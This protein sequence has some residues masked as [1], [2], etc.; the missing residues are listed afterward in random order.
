MMRDFFYPYTLDTA[1][2][3]AN[4]LSEATWTLVLPFYKDQVVLSYNRQ[5][6]QWELPGGH[7]EEGETPEDTAAR[8]C[9]EET[10]GTPGSLRLIG[11]IPAERA[12]GASNLGLVYLAEIDHL[13]D[14][15]DDGEIT[16]RAVLKAD[17]VGLLVQRPGARNF[18]HSLITYA[19][20]LQDNKNLI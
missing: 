13:G 18:Y 20:S 6:Q 17:E 5:R 7:R 1:E 14:L 8:E 12:C 2:P 10:G 11:R 9:Y 19:R 16:H 3:T 15:P 4:E